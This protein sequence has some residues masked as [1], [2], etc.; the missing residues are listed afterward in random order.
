MSDENV[1][2]DYFIIGSS[3][4]IVLYPCIY[5]YH[6]YSRLTQEEKDDSTISVETLLILLPLLF[7]GGLVLFNKLLAPIIPRKIHDS[8]YPRFIFAGVLTSF[9]LSI[10][11][12]YIFHIQDTWLHMSN[13]E[14]S[15]IIV[16]VFY[17]VVFS[18]LGIW[19]RAHIL[20]GPA[21]MYNNILPASSSNAP[22]PRPIMKLPQIQQP[23]STDSAK[24]FD[25][26]ASI[27]KEYNNS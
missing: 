14:L 23:K 2:I 17:L 16:P 15:H 11:F 22:S 5:L 4:F 12:Q 18:T 7:G 13:P 10:I 9:V 25:K 24:V 20:Y 3:P 8:Y 27:N 1:D 26:L 6:A 21:T 19:M